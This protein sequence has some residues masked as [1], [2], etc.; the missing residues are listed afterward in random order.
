M[1]VRRR[2]YLNN[3]DL[4][5]EIAKSKLSYCEI[6]DPEQTSDYDL[7]VDDI[8]QI[9]DQQFEEARENR[10]ARLT[11]LAL[12]NLMKEGMTAKQAN[13]EVDRVRVNVEDIKNSDIIIREM[14]YAHIPEV[15]VKPGKMDYPR[16]NFPPFKQ[17]RLKG[18][19]WEEVVRSHWVGGFEN[20]WFQQDHGQL[21][22][23]L[24]KMIM[25]LVEKFSQKGNWRGYSYIADMRG[26]A[27][28]HLVDVALKFNEAKS[29]NP[30]AFYTTVTSNNFKGFLGTEKRMRTMR[31]DLMMAEGFDPSFST[32][33]DHEMA[34]YE[35]EL[36]DSKT[37]KK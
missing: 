15:E 13:A 36:Q 31:D 12:E 10:A 8:G 32:M 24:A 2:N 23:E 30:F 27:I 16:L 29:D 37:K 33:I 25:L 7:I 5:K 9:S 28:T 11:K 19:K 35:Q 22:N 1:A 21:T 17:Y 14:T 34:I 3:I 20:G 18:K 4:L 6:I 26:T